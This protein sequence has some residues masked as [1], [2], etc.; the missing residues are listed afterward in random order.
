[1]ARESV[2]AS[3]GQPWRIRSGATPLPHVGQHTIP[4]AGRAVDWV[5]SMPGMPLEAL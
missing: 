3:N 2:A 1:M 5:S 4:V